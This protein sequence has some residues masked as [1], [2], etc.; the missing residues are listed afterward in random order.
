METIESK[1]AEIL[2]MIGKL[3]KIYNAS[4]PEESLSL[5]SSK[6]NG[7][8][9]ETNEQFEKIGVKDLYVCL[10]DTNEIGLF[11]KDSY[12]MRY[13]HHSCFEWF[14]KSLT[15]SYDTYGEI[16]FGYNNN[17]IGLVQL[18][19]NG[20]A[21]RR[22][23]Q[24]GCSAKVGEETYYSNVFIDDSISFENLR[25]KMAIAGQLDEYTPGQTSQS[26]IIKVLTYAQSYF[27]DKK[28]KVKTV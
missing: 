10:Y 7:L 2:D 18:F 20:R 4:Y 16:Y 1:K 23:L 14:E 26:E 8:L 22:K 5:S 28:A 25:I 24:A 3:I 6:G 21:C 15:Y 12:Y 11:K 27:D 19:E 17:N 9:K 13:T